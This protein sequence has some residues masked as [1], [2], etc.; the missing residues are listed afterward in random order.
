V[1][2]AYLAGIA[3]GIAASWLYAAALRARRTRQWQAQLATKTATRTPTNVTVVAASH[4]APGTVTYAPGRAACPG[5]HG[6]GYVDGDAWAEICSTCHGS[7]D[8][9]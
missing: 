1:T 9:A 3:S 5:C 8:A 4:T 7:G 2:A 6:E